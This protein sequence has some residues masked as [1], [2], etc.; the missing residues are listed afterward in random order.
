M[1]NCTREQLLLS[2]LT[3]LS[4]EIRARRQPEYGYT[5]ASVAGFGAVAWGV[6]TLKAINSPLAWPIIA[7]M[8]GTILVAGAVIYKICEE[9]KTYSRLRKELVEIFTE[10]NGSILPPD[11]IPTGF[12]DIRSGPG[13]KWSICIVGTAAIGAILFCLSLLLKS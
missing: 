4:E 10:L 13:Y 7:A 3:Q 8:I 2:L 9:N 11:K 1:N 5:A 6:A 12:R